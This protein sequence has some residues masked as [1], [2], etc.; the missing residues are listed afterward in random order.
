[1]NV[2]I[3]QIIIIQCSG[4]KSD[5]TT[6]TFWDYQAALY[7]CS[8]L[9]VHRG[10]GSDLEGLENCRVQIAGREMPRE[11]ARSGRRVACLGVFFQGLG[12]FSMF[13]QG[14]GGFFQGLG[15]FFQG[16]GGFSRV[17]V[18]FPGFGWI[19]PRF[20]KVFL[21]KRVS[22]VVYSQKIMK[23]QCIF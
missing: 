9:G 15:G 10:R 13:F 14:L 22:F 17:W 23:W 20:P 2:I 1:M 7:R 19:F 18:V 16:L 12:G 6:G 4:S 11:V 5:Q 8:P 3:A 21:E